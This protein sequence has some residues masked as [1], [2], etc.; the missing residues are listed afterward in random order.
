MPVGTDRRRVFELYIQERNVTVVSVPSR[1]LQ[2]ESESII[3]THRV[4]REVR[5]ENMPLSK[6]PR[7]LPYKYLR[8]PWGTREGGH[9]S[10]G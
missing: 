3:H 1:Q 8:G 4:S 7:S 10:L 2:T 5:S 9:G 6:L